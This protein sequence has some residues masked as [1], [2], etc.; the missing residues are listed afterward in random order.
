MPGAGLSTPLLPFRP[1]RRFMVFTSGVDGS[2]RLRVLK[3]APSL[4]L[5]EAAVCGCY[6]L[7]RIKRPVELLVRIS[8]EEGSM[9]RRYSTRFFPL[10]TISGLALALAGFGGKAVA[11]EASRFQVKTPLIIGY[12]AQDLSNPYWQNYAAGVKAQAATDKVDVV[13]ADAKA[14]QQNQVSGS[15]NLISQSISALI[16]SPV[17]PAALPGSVSAAH[18]A[19]IPIVIGDVGASGEYDAFIQSDNRA[20]GALAADYM[21]KKLGSGDVNIAV[22]TLHPGST[23]GTDRVGGFET[24]LKRF[25]NIHVVSELN[26]NDAIKEGHDAAANALAKNPDI[27]GIYA[28][29]DNE[30]QGAI[31][32]IEEAGRSPKD[33]VIIGFDGNAGSIAA[34]GN[35]TQTATIAQDPFGQGQLAVKTALQLLK[36]QKVSYTD[37]PTK[38]IQLAVQLIDSSNLAQ[39]KDARAGQK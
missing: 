27:K 20:G 33:F 31:A 39:F 14:S 30:A 2:R 13:V 23:V 38:T 21:V 18:R 25:P 22:I 26:G 28:A 3:Q 11:E 24:E 29:N 35:G 5:T 7:I 6:V 17:E 16:V 9:D 1:A 34:I 19:S 36:G 10:A 12:T 32:A 4:E 37:V 15:R 8:N